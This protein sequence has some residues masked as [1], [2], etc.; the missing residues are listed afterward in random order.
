MPISSTAP[1]IPPHPQP[2]SPIVSLF[3]A[4]LQG[5][6]NLLGLLP[7]EAYRMPIGPLGYSRRSIVVVNEPK[8]VREVLVDPQGI[9]PK[10][11]LMVNAL[12][13]LIGDSIFV[14]S[15]PTW[16][17][18]RAMM[19]PALTLM[20]VNRA[21]AS[22]EAGAAEYEETLHRQAQSGALFSL[23]LAMS[24]LTADIICRSVFSTSLAT[25][26]AHEVFDAFTFFE[27]S[28]AQV[29]IRR[30]IMDRAWTKI[31]QTQAVLESCALIRR[32]LGDL[33]D[34]HLDAGQ[35]FD[36]IASAVVAA[37]DVEGRAFTREE[38][39]DQ[40]GVLFLAGHETSASALTWCFYLLA[41]RPE[42]VARIRAEVAEVCGDGPVTFEHTK[43][44]VFTR[45][46]FNE[47][48]RLYPPI[49]FLPRVANEATR[50]GDYKVKRGALIMVAPWVLHR[51]R[52]Y[53]KDPNVFDP[54]RFTAERKA[55]LVQGAYIPFGIGPR[56]CAGAAFATVEATLLIA[57]LFRHFD[58]TV[59]NP[60]AVRPAA[61]L[62]TRPTRQV[63]CRVA[64]AG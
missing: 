8:L 17:R 11:D 63:M 52:L 13:P 12:E 7:A 44:L 54:D 14:S 64:S 41:T 40:L 1:F 47:T 36:D 53:W 6:G 61:R 59:E 33:L 49:T 2:R 46:V 28:V 23:D 60:E 25:T 34:S 19:D 16:K 26:V 38:L 32:C 48:L 35:S 58:F 15:G 4:V 37:H 29:E 9:F 24:H 22:M 62:T 3:R 5:E 42:L 18:Q 31:P 57:R 50:I 55:E 39:I 56:I 20:R 51:H 43:R 10:S 30:L 21:F 45:N 27:R